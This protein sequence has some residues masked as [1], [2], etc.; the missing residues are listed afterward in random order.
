MNVAQRYIAVSL[1]SE[2]VKFIDCR[3]SYWQNNTNSPDSVKWGLLCPSVTE[4]G[5]GSEVTGGGV[6][7]IAGG[8]DEYIML[9]LCKIH[10]RLLPL[11]RNRKGGKRRK[12]SDMLL[13]KRVS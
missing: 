3:V 5:R 10:S 8:G 13:H 6:H 2:K 9:R 4:A 7:V 11:N 1:P 12:G